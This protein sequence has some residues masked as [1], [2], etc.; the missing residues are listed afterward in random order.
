MR[1]AYL[2]LAHHHPLHLRRLVRALSGTAAGI[3]V[4]VDAK[5]DIAPFRA[6]LSGTGATLLRDRVGVWHR[7][8]SMVNATLRLL[9]AATRHAPPFDRYVLLSG[10]DYPVRP[11]AEILE[12]YRG[13]AESWIGHAVLRPETDD[14][15]RHLAKVSYPDFVLFNSRWGKRSPLRRRIQKRVLRAC[16][17]WVRKPDP[18]VTVYRGSQW[19]SLT[20]EMAVFCLAYLSDPAN[21]A[22]VRFFKLTAGSDELVFQTLLLNSRFAG[23]CRSSPVAGA[24]LYSCLHYIDWSPHRE[25][26]AH[27]SLADLPAITASGYLFARKTVSPAS[28]SLLAALDLLRG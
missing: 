20:H 18:G 8:Y 9:D 7:G 13:S 22:F 1:L 27:L 3:F 14:Q 17:A 25:E 26:P 16:F 2:I 28:D 23:S 12:H 10:D 11:D 4:H 5:A 24:S 15:F 6:A 21:R 19:W